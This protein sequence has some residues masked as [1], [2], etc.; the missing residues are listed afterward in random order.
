MLNGETYVPWDED[1]YQDK[2]LHPN[3]FG[4][5]HYAMNLL[6]DLKPLLP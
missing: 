2:V 1:M 4:M 3:D 5:A 6:A